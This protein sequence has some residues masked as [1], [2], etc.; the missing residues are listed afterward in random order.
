MKERLILNPEYSLKGWKKLPYAVYDGER[1]KAT[2]LNKQQFDLV[3]KCSGKKDIDMDVLD[4]DQKDFLESL[5]KHKVVRPAEAGETRDLYY[6][7]YDNIYKQTVHWSITGRCN[8]HCRHCFQSAPCGELM[9]PT[10]EQCKDIIHQFAECGIGSVGITGG[11]PL[12]HPDFLAIV[13]ELLANHISINVI[14]SNGRLV[15]QELLDELHKRGLHTGFQISFDGVGYHDWMRGVPG[16]EKTALDA[17]RLLRKNGHGVSC[18]MCL[19]RENIGSLRETVKVLAEAGCGALKTQCASPQGLWANQKE[20][21][22]TYD[23]TLQAYLD[24]IPMYAEDKTPLALQMEGFFS[25]DPSTQT[26]S[27]LTDK[28]LPEDFS[29]PYTGMPV[30]GVVHTSFYVGPSGSVVPCMSLDYIEMT[31][32]F[33]NLYGM[34]LKQILSDSSFTKF[35]SLRVKDLLDHTAECRE[36]E[37]RSRCCGGCRAFAAVNN[38]S[39]YLAMD[40]VSCKIL[41]E[42][43]DQKLYAVGDKYFKRAERQSPEEKAQKMV[44]C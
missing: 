2:F 15:T 11:E 38:P 40:N 17:I 26:Y 39:D 25:Y 14:Y 27:C 24:Y 34:P 12:V 19:C 9:Q 23:E 4:E 30:C 41:K 31:G 7:F 13:D 1:K 3:L 16:A 10:L 21:F 37:H 32:Q 42:G 43:W 18:A 44:D 36:C 29:V 8:Y 33:P 5:K 22:L 28:T 20:H 6:K 35:M